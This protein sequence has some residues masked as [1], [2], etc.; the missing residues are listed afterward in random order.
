MHI[1]T[2]EKITKAYTEKPLLNDITLNIS[3]GDKIGL[4]G[5]NGTGKSTLLKIIA[6]V[7]S[8][9]L[10]EI[11][12]S[13]K[14]II[15]Y[16]PQDPEFANDVTVL[17]QVFKSSSP[18]IKLIKEYEQALED[19]NADSKNKEK[20]NKLL[21]LSQKMDENEAWN[22]ESEAKTILSKLGI[23]N[24]SEK[25]G[26]LSGGQKK[27]V[28]LAGVLIS[29][30][31]LLILDEPTNHLDNE[32][33]QWLER[34]LNN[35]S[36]ALLM[37]THDRYF[38]GRVCNRITELDFG[39]IYNYQANYVEYLELKAARME[40]ERAS[41]RKRQSILRKE[42]AWIK[43]GARA[44]STKQKAR[45]ERYDDLKNQKGPE[46]YESLNIQGVSSRLGKKTIEL[47][48]IG[49]SY[50]ANN[51]IEDFSYILD[52]ED[53][54]GIIGLN[55]AGKSTLLKIIAGLIPPDN[56]EVITG[57]TVKIAYFGQENPELNE[58]LK[59]IEYIRETAE[60]I[61]T[62]EGSISASQMLEEFLFPPALQWNLISKL[63]GGEKRRLYLLKVLMEAPN[64]ILLDE[65]TND[66]DIQTLTVLESYLE[67]FSGAVIA[68]SHDRYFI[69][70]VMEKIFVFS[71]EG[72]IE[73]FHGNYSDYYEEKLIDESNLRK[74]QIKEKSGREKEKPVKLTFIEQKEYDEIDDLIIN[75][76]NEIN[77]LA[78]K[79]NESAKDYEVLKDLLQK[80]EQLDNKLNKAM[81]RWIYLNEI[82]E[83]MN[84][85]KSK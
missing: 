80:K 20:E 41:E 81:D 38:L 23:T 56:G 73:I 55:G 10:G 79:I 49:K 51:L 30:C 43:R 27:R 32:I 71:G 66:L 22:I 64:V 68:V 5:V 69:D 35:R 61:E 53:R 8:C 48:N 18:M 7:E 3:D 76:E 29:E 15:E 2:A 83:I 58:K 50:G 31:D 12:T 82:A 17:E 47:I 28:A 75:L 6:G 19:Y 33:I 77:N 44:R 16:L 57:E 26:L 37:V 4:I 85:N 36:G 59:V 72:K 40:Q 63:S 52:K 11:K 74:E 24:F 70:R 1:L 84:K 21:I 13:K 9:D 34:Y 25:A 39:K 62:V 67:D 54:I 65:P 45:I 42:L 46:E 14:T 60:Y 78:N